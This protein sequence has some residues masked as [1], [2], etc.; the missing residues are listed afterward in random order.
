MKNRF[1]VLGMFAIL[2]LFVGISAKAQETGGDEGFNGTSAMD[3]NSALAASLGYNKIGDQNYVGMRI[4]PELH[5]GKLGLGLDIPLMINVSSGKLRTDEFKNGAGVLRMIR[6]ASWG[7]KKNDPF[8]VRVGD[9]SNSYLGYGLLVNNF[10]NSVSFEKRKVGIEWDLCIKNFI[11][12][13][14]LYSDFNAASTNLLGLRPYIRPFGLGDIP[15]LKTVEIGASYVTDHDKTSPLVTNG[16]VTNKLVGS[17]ISAQG[18][19]LGVT[20][21]NT[22]FLRL[23]VFAQYG[24]LK[25]S[26]SMQDSI[27]KYVAP[28]NT[29]PTAEQ[30]AMVS[31]YKDGTGISVGTSFSFRILGNVLRADAKL[32]RLWYS[33]YFAPQFFDMG[34][35][36]NKDAKMATL[37]SA[38]KKQGTYGDLSVTVLDKIRVGGALLMPDAVS[39]TNPA[40]IKFDLDASRLL[41]KFV[42]TGTYI[43]SGLTTLGDALKIDDRSLAQI[44]MAY[45]YNSFLVVGFDYRWTWAGQSDGSFKAINSIMPYVGFSMQLPFG[46]NS[47]GGGN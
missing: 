25:K 10:T 18:V 8:F 41:E 15:V 3:Q 1:L 36:L 20:L 11:G 43:K 2:L 9:I 30:K 12:I 22:S 35:E 33:D 28:L 24:M 34:Y 4:A 19:D 14:G 27:D 42:V 31:G 44:R 23:V 26:S 7:V 46:N 39:S 21:V 6:Y 5:I 13:E 37:L 45:K 16:I 47:N 17:G 29:T 38:A 32:E 40:F